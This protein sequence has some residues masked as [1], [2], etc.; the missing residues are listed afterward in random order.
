MRSGCVTRMVFALGVSVCAAWP[1]AAQS[2][3]AMVVDADIPALECPTSP[4]SVYFAAGEVLASDQ[5]RAVIGK[6]QATVRDCVPDQVVLVAIVDSELEG[7][8]AETRARQRLDAISGE[9]V[10][11]GV[12]AD[13]IFTALTPG[14]TTRTPESGINSVAVMLR[15]VREETFAPSPRVLDGAPVAVPVAL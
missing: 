15:K 14:K 7:E 9:L 1:V 5:S 6:L 3:P 2:A 11:G 4:L 8:A 13:R 12:A 10:A